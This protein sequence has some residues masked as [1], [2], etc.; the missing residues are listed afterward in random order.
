MVFVCLLLL[1][2]CLEFLNIFL[3]ILAFLDVELRALECGHEDLF[4]IYV[5][6]RAS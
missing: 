5:L 4:E 6:L 1:W 3:I 2:E